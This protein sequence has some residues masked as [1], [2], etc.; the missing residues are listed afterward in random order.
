MTDAFPMIAKTLFG[1]EDV[2][3]AELEELGALDVQTGNRMCSFRGDLRML[4]RAN[5]ECRTAVRV[6]KPI[7]RF[8]ADGTDALYRRI[9][10]TNW[11]K[12]LEPEGSLAIDPV[13]NGRVFTNSLYAAQVAKDG[14]VDQIRKR[15]GQR[16]SVDLEDPD[17]RINL[18][19]AHKR[20]TVY[21]DASGDSL[22]KRGYRQA[23]GEAPLG[24]V[25]AAG[26]LRLV[27]WDAASP[28][29]DFM[30][31]SGTFLI[32]AALLARRIAPGTLRETFGYMRWKDYCP[33]THEEVLAAARGQELP[34]LSF[35]IQGSDCDGEVVN[36]AWE[37]A[38]GARVADDV[39][40]KVQDFAEARP[41][42][43]GGILLTNP[44][45]EE[46]IKTNDIVAL[47]RH[48]G[49]VLKHHWAGYTAHI[50]T[51]NREAAKFIGLRPAARIKLFNGPIECRLLKFG[52]YALER[53]PNPE[54]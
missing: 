11:L 44:P 21:L 36:V 27:G 6:L 26:I 1:L 43:P 10:R 45:Y 12:H 17:V 47:Y 29:A 39:I 18:H 24:E 35:P 9:G 13:V 31:G 38:R 46:R 32:E 34:N 19:I 20:V 37:N 7:A 50:L 28:L 5:V 40:W 51:G 30:C 53:K 42:A 41:P 52:I 22:H 49:D 33:A 14:I 4:Y 3:A 25:L 54:T 23:A 15:T 16:P 2:L 48:I 8:P